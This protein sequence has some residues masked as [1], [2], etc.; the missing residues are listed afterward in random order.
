MKAVRIL[1]LVF[2]PIALLGFGQARFSAG[3]LVSR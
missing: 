3:A 2:L 1:S